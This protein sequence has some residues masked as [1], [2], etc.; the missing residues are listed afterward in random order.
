VPEP[1]VTKNRVHLD[2]N[3]GGGRQIP[4][5]E[6]RARVE[7]EVDRLRRAGATPLRP[8]EEQGEY[9]VV[10]AAPEGNEFYLR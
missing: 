5:Q 7:A 6:R 3:V 8:V 9:W 4:L 2:L 10:M 1:K